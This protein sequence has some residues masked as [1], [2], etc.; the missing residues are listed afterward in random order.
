LTQFPDAVRAAIDDREP[1]FIPDK[2]VVVHS[3]GLEEPMKERANEYCEDISRFD[4][5]ASAIYTGS[6]INVQK[7]IRWNERSVNVTIRDAKTCYIADSQ[8]E[9]RVTDRLNELIDMNVRTDTE[10][11]DQI[12]NMTRQRLEDL[13]YV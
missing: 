2:P 10:D 12:D 8:K 11:I 1:T 3:D 5:K 9:S 4:G 7:T 6:G 13:G